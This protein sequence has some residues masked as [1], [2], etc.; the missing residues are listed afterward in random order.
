MMI[1]FVWLA[2]VA[3]G[4]FLLIALAKLAKAGK[5]LTRQSNRLNRALSEFSET[6]HSSSQL[7]PK[8]GPTSLEEAEINRRSYLKQRTK[9]KEERQRRLVKRLRNLLSKE[10]E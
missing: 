1:E 4:L 6:D 9:S 10:S 3:A 2:P 7:V 5:R 8:F